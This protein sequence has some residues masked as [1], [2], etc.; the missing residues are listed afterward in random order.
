MLTRTVSLKADKDDAVRTRRA[1]GRQSRRRMAVRRSSRLGPIADADKDEGIED[2]LDA[3]PKV[4]GILN[5]NPKKNGCP[6]DRDNDD[7]HVVDACPDVAGRKDPDP[8][9]NGCPIADRDKD[10]IPDEKDACA[11][12]AGAPTNDPT[13]NGCP[14]DATVTARN[15]TK[16]RASMPRARR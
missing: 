9:K 4:A 3:C 8:K 14:S 6:S 16:T 1:F 7:I 15:T 2:A 5:A 10:G 11:E 12:L 13:T